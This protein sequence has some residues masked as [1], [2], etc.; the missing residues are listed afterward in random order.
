[1]LKIKLPI[2]ILLLAGQYAFTQNVGIDNTSP[3]AKLDINGDIA[4]R[5][6]DIDITST[7]LYA[8]DVNTVKQSN[9]KLKANILLGNFIIAGITSGVDGRVITLYNRTGNSMEIYNEDATS[10][11]DDRIQTGT[12]A[13]IAVYDKGNVVLQYDETE[14]RWV[15]QSLHNNSLNYFGSGGGTSYWDLDGA[16]ISNNNTGNVGIG[17][18]SPVHSRL[19]ITGRVGAS[20]ALFGSDA[21][22]VGISANNPEI[23][24]NYFYN[25]DTKTIKAGYAANFGMDPGNGNVYLGNFAGNQSTT[26]FGSITGYQNVMTITQSGNVGIGTGSPSLKLDIVGQGRL[27]GS[28]LSSPGLFGSLTGGGTLFIRNSTDANTLIMD[29]G[30]I[31]VIKANLQSSGSTAAPLLLNPYGGSVG[32][33]TTDPGLYKL[34]V[35]GSVRAKEVRINTGWAD[36]VFE[37]DY[38]LTPLPTVENFIKINK[39]L[40]GILPASVIEKEGADIGHTQTK[41]LEKIEELTLYMIEANKSILLLQQR[42]AQLETKK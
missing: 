7:Y 31:Q 34:A 1:M 13:T 28:P 39:H 23:G 6:A 16:N 4:F 36:Y 10:L 32:I 2:L 29:A 27:V 12:G 24:F 37:P 11:A 15:I 20:V 35:N 5:S 8:L 17:T 22:G 21:F 41:L 14:H 33:G 38:P 3:L 42:I 25:N 19:E 18:N 40:P 30:K 26:D 9:Y